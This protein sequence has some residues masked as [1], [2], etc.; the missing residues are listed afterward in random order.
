MLIPARG[1]RRGAQRGYVGGTHLGSRGSSLGG[2]LCTACSVA[3]S[4]HQSANVRYSRCSVSVSSGELATVGHAE[5]LASKRSGPTDTG[6]RN[7]TTTCAC[8]TAARA[9]VSRLHVVG[10]RSSQA[11]LPAERSVRMLGGG[12]ADAWHGA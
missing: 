11:L 9:R 6:P 3:F 1:C 8:A 4:I 7:V 10:G 2:L 12:V 5:E